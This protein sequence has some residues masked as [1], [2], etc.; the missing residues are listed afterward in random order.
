MKTL[1]VD[2]V[3]RLVSLYVQPNEGHADN[4]KQVMGWLQQAAEAGKSAIWMGDMNC[5]M[6]PGSDAPLKHVWEEFCSEHNC[7]RVDAQ[8]GWGAVP[9]RQ[10]RGAE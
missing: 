10:P 6:L 8:A 5:N 4:T 3:A 7:E 9:T 2:K 1:C